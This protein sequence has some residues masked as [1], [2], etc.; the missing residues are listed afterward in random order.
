MSLL[1]IGGLALIEV[2]GDFALKDFANHGGMGSLATG[3][4]GYVGVVYFLIRS[5]QGSQ[6][7]LVNVAWDAMSAIIET[8]SAI[9][10]LGEGFDDFTQYLGIVFIAMGL[11]F[12]K[13]PL[14]RQREF[15]FPA[16]FK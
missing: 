15:V 3:I 9:V 8:I 13:I 6:V 5:L 14:K 2:I 4:A 11:F 12:L 7:I 1:D 10:F 16:F